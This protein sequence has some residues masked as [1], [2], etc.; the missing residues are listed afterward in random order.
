MFVVH[1]LSSPFFIRTLPSVSE[2]Y[3]LPTIGRVRKQDVTL[4]VGT[5][6]LT[7]SGLVSWRRHGVDLSPLVVAPAAQEDHPDSGFPEQEEPPPEDQAS[8]PE[9][10]R[11]G[12][13]RPGNA[14][15]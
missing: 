6:S 11:A 2:P 7:F 14:P 4:V 1:L 8:G 10:P 15:R 9:E 3:Q 12:G 5:S 13:L